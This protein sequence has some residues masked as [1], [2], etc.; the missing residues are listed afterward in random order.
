MPIYCNLQ[1]D[2]CLS[3]ARFMIFMVCHLPFEA[4]NAIDFY[5]KILK[6]HA[7]GLAVFSSG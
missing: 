1:G 5:L 2:F 4:L 7:F 6:Q 3:I